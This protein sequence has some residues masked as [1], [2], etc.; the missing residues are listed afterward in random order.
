MITLPNKKYSTDVLN[1]KQ[2]FFLASHLPEPDAQTGRPAYS[3]QVLLPGILR[4]LRSGSRWRDLDQFE[5]PSHVSHWRRLRYW[6]RRLGINNVW[7]MLLKILIK[8]ESHKS[9]QIS[10]VSLDGSLVPSHSFKDTASY[11]GKHKRV[12]TKVSLLVSK[13]GLP[14]SCL[15]ASGATH[16]MPLAQPTVERI[17]NIGLGQHITELLADR[18]YASSSFAEFLSQHLITPTIAKKRPTIVWRQKVA[19]LAHGKTERMSEPVQSPHLKQRYVV[20]RTNAW[21]K[22]FRRL[23]FR[24]DYSL[25]SFSAFQTLAYVVILVRRLI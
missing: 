2:L 6:Q 11:S 15:F 20:E 17:I 5:M 14:L 16:D 4:I 8:K 24:F 9:E 22:S 1:E 18:G 25:L 13:D 12:G 21:S 10:P 3:N 23:K 7:E 19:L